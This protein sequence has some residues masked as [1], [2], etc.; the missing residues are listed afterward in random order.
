MKGIIPVTLPKWGLEM[1]EGTVTAWHVTEGSRAEAGADLC[2]VETDKIVN[3]MEVEKPGILRRILV[4]AGETV[5]VG[6]LIAVI[7]DD[8]V[9]DAALDR[10]IAEYRP[11]DASFEPQAAAP[12]AHVAPA[13]TPAATVAATPLA[14]RTAAEAGVDLA[15]VTGSGPKGKVRR[16]DVEG[17][18]RQAGP[19]SPVH[20]SP[21]A[22]KFAR[23]IGLSLTGIA[24]TGRKGRISLAD[25]Q[26]AAAAA[27]LWS[28]PAPASAP[29]SAAPLPAPAETPFSPLRKAI[30]R[31]LTGSK[32]T[33]PHFYTAMDVETD[34]LADLR[35]ALNAAGDG[36]KVSVNDL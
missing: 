13:A 12:A 31:T 25:A 8:R 30:A 2:D 27:G 4:P 10:F 32:A 33:V 5:A 18:A 34:A 24:G 36:T 14:R 20:A 22:E 7:A 1:A 16:D 6:T 35:A 19:A 11:V 23:A 29:P 28:P 9:E 26:A 3:S 17:A 15:S 21:V